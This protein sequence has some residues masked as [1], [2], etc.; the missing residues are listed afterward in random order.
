LVQK[1]ESIFL[2]KSKYLNLIFYKMK[3]IVP[4]IL[5][6]LI[7]LAS[8][9]NNERVYQPKPKG[10]HRLALPE[11]EYMP[12]EGDYPYTFQVSKHAKVEQD[13][14]FMAQ[15]SWI[16]V[17]YPEFGA[18]IDISYKEISDSPDS[19]AGFVATSH[20]LTFK[21]QAKATKI[22]EYVAKGGK[23]GTLNAMLFDLEGEIPS[24]F[25][26]Y[27]HDSTKHFFRAALYFNTASKND[28]IQP[29]IEY[30]KLDMIQML[31][32]LEFKEK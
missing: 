30:L 19:L 1:W 20:R 31:N 17:K 2:E 10:Y 22:E 7:F 11:H 6:A 24:Q 21:H 25:H 16:E 28:S 29:I 27:A 9:G 5:V 23:G 4:V 15:P 12:L 26:F 14:H 32:T 8:C 3:S 18:E 13:K